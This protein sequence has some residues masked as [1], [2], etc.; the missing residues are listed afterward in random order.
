MNELG[1][2]KLSL[3]DLAI[4]S[5]LVDQGRIGPVADR[6]G[7]SN[8]AVSY[9]VDRLR[10]AFD[11]PLLIRESH[12]FRATQTGAA[13]AAIATEFLIAFASRQSPAAFDP[14]N[15]QRAFT[16]VATD[17]ELQGFLTSVLRDFMAAGAGMTVSLLETTPAFD[18]ERLH[19]D[20]DIAFLP[21][22]VDRASIAQTLLFHDA[23]VTFYDPNHR[24]APDTLA[25]FC[26]AGHAMVT[27]SGRKSSNIDTALQK[28]EESRRIRLTA[29]SF[30]ALASMMRGTDLVTTLPSR[31]ARG[32]FAGFETV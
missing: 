3:R 7:I 22:A 32:A 4:L 25:E 28:L 18:L 5:A 23:Y 2:S 29:P 17:Y 13:Y 11:D 21:E 30:L 15:S 26:A 9:A 16:L 24:S 31:F 20:L 14:A 19:T 10:V 6:F 1:L 8:S 27:A 12:G